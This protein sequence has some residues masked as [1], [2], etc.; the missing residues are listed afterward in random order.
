MARPTKNDIDSGIQNWHQKIDDNDEVLFNGPLPIHVHTGDETDLAATFPVASYD[1]CIVVVNHSALG[2]TLY[3]SD[4]TT[5]QRLVK[6]AAIAVTALTDSSGGT[7]N[8]T[9]AA[10][11]QAANPGSADVGPTADA[12]ADLAAKVNEIRTALVNHGLLS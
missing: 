9:I 12:I 4:G 10:I 1:R 7:A 11:T 6:F 3:A 5:W 8:N 2:W